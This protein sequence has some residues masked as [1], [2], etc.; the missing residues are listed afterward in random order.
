MRNGGLQFWKR[1][2]EWRFCLGVRK[3]EYKGEGRVGLFILGKMKVLN[4]LLFFFIFGCVVSWNFIGNKL[5][6]SF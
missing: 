3:M 1:E 5:F 6:I 4:F 2:K